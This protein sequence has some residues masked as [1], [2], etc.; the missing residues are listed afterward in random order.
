[1][2]NKYVA[3]IIKEIESSL[4]TQLNLEKIKV[5]ENRQ[6]YWGLI[7]QPEKY[8]LKFMVPPKNADDWVYP[9]RKASLINES[10]LLKN[11]LYFEDLYK[12]G[13]I[14][15]NY[16]WLLLKW[17]EG[18]SPN[19][20]LNAYREES[21]K[22]KAGIKKFKATTVKL[23]IRMAKALEELHKQGIIHRDIQPSHFKVTDKKITILDYGQ[24]TPMGKNSIEYYGA[25]I[26]F[27][28]PEV[29][30][31]IL[32]APQTHYD[33]TLETEI[34]S[35]ASTFYF[36]YSE[37]TSTDYGLFPDKMPYREKLRLITKKAAVKF[38]KRDIEPFP[39][40]E[41]IL[42]ACMH[43]KPEKRPN[44]AS[45]IEQLGKIK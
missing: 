4:D 26:H 20:Y 31:H 6:T 36:L 18:V 30:A 40:L 8:F 10:N 39:K 27:N 37:K 22:G 38:D 16:V 1:M 41:K 23:F 5:V 15:E 17:I 19:K 24:S 29:C 45:L 11:N 21:S 9:Y 33:Y 34:Y 25:L 44:L 35:L 43:K 28:P 2:N 42:R 32:Q 3:Y 13:A 7:Q 12:D 14:K